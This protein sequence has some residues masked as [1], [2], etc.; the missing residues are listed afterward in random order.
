MGKSERFLALSSEKAPYAKDPT[1]RVLFWSTL[2]HRIL[3]NPPMKTGVRRPMG[4][5]RVLGTVLGDT[6]PDH[7]NNSLYR[8]PTFYY[9]GT[10][11]PLG[12]SDSLD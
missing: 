9:I 7:N 10:L 12:A 8:N 4:P 5:Q 6:F 11:D 3:G 1:I 2:R